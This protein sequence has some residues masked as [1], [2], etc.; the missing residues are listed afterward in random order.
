MTAEQALPAMQPAIQQGEGGST[1]TV[2]LLKGEWE[3]AKC[4]LEIAQQ[5]TIR[6]HYSA[7]GSNTRVLT[8]GLWRKAEWMAHQCAGASWWIPPTKTCGAS[9]FPENPQGVL[10][11]SRLVVVPEAPRNA[12]SFLIRHSMRFIDRTR[13]P[14]LVTYADEWQ[15]HTGGIYKALKDAGWR[16]DGVTKPEKTYVDAEGRMRSRKAGNRTKTHAE[17]LALGYECKGSFSRKRFV[18]RLYPMDPCHARGDQP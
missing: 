11:L 8:C 2:R 1:P 9:I 16:E 17:M 4:S 15:G 6:F 14:V 18:H 7:G 5:L 12:C 3:V 10:S 13:W